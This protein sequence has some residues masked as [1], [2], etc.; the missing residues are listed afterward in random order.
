MP[1]LNLLPPVAIEL[2]ELQLG[3][4]RV[5]LTATAAFHSLELMKAINELFNTLR[6]I[7]N[8]LF[9]KL[10]NYFKDYNSCSNI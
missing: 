4:I 7:N 3:V 10:L 2:K 1:K 6:S 9:F 5:Y 8:F